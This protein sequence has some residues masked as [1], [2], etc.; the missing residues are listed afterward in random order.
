MKLRLNVLITALALTHFAIA[1]EDLREG[2]YSGSTNNGIS[3][4]L[5]ISKGHSV[6]VGLFW[7]ETSNQTGKAV[8][9]SVKKSTQKG[10]ILVLSGSADFTSAKARI[11]LAAD[12][13]P[14]EAKMGIGSFFK[15]GY[16]IDCKNLMKEIDNQ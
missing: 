16:D 11:T 8:R 2:N 5:S 13:T 10:N 3:C 14:I 9:F 12:G 15:V 6:N 4:H 7:E 1:N